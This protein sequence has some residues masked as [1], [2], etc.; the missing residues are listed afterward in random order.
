M[1]TPLW[2]LVL[3]A[4][5]PI[6]LAIFGVRLR[7]QQ[8]GEIDNHHPRVQATELRGVA[9]R[10]YGAQQNAWEALALFSAAVFTAHLAG[11][12]PGASAAAA[13]VFVAARV[14]H[15]IFYIRDLP[16][17]RGM[18]FATGLLCCLTLFG[19]AASA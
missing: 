15:A 18:A 11:A 7:T 16:A 10:A 14:L 9:A 13:M 5:A 8:L 6:A 4:L 17:P 3:V 12:S 1:T 2:C 19:L